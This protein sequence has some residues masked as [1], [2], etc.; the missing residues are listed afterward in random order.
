MKA[1]KLKWYSPLLLLFGAI[2]SFADPMTDILT[3][4]KFY[5]ADRKIWFVVGLAFI[6]L[7]C[8]VFAIVYSV[9]R[10]RDLSQYSD[11]R[12]CGQVF[13]CGFHPFSCALVRL[14]GFF[15]F[16]K[17]WLRSNE[18]VPGDITLA[19]SVGSDDLVTHI[20]FAVL[21]ESVVESAPQF[22]IQLYA[23]SVQEEPVEVI[24]ILSLAVSFVSLTWAFT[25]A[26]EIIHEGHIIPLKIRHKLA[27]F[28]T[29]SFL[30][31]SRLFAVCYF[32]VSYK[33]LVLIVLSFHTL[34]IAVADNIRYCLEK[35]S[36][37]IHF[38]FGSILFVCAHWLRDDLAAQQAE[39]DGIDTGNRKSTVLRLQLFSN[40]LFVLENLIM[41]LLFYFSEKSNTWYSLPVTV[42]VCLLGVMGAVIR[43]ALF[44]FL[45]LLSD[46]DRYSDRYSDIENDSNYNETPELNNNDNSP[47]DAWYVAPTV[48]L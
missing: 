1:R 15:H 45:L 31:S 36:C 43:I 46:S 13:L 35:G 33:W 14:Q 48:W 9:F 10:D 23:A 21:F 42:C 37:G 4:V 39:D 3:L 20:D 30:L 11:S 26:D 24:Q 32:T 25:I 7:P 16:L 29:H 6:I 18:I 47:D 27:L 5:R 34:V 41:I 19:S 40:V 28:V 12:K 22:I 17:K 44:K 2:L 38:G 8:L